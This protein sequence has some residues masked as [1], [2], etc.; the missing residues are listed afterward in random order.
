M[1]TKLIR[2]RNNNNNKKKKWIY[3]F[4]NNKYQR[5]SLISFLL[6]IYKT[7]HHNKANNHN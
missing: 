5:N 2:K 3:L 1:I 4:L 6:Q 7:Y